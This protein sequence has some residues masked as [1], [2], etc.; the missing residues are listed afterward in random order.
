M[1]AQSVDETTAIARCEQGIQGLERSSPRSR[2]AGRKAKHGAKSLESHFSGEFAGDM[3]GI[4]RCPLQTMLST[5][6]F[7]KHPGHAPTM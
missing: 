7:E 4:S 1:T 3:M 6:V 5:C 2:I